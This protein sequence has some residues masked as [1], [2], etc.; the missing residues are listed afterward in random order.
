MADTAG[1]PTTIVLKGHL[2]LRQDEYKAAG[3]I[4]PGDLIEY[5]AAGDVLVHGT[6]GGTA[7]K[8]F[9]KEDAL[10]GKTIN[11]AYAVGDPVFTHHAQLGDL[12]W[13]RLA[14]SQTVAIDSELVSAGAGTLR[15]ATTAADYRIAR[16][17][18][19]LT[20]SVSTTTRVRAEIV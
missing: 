5:D 10:Q 4:N 7:A 18:T 2:H 11:D 1:N 9:A 20:A 16:S 15:V 14:A 6:T 3:A 17:K 13:A 8:M 19:A 12:I